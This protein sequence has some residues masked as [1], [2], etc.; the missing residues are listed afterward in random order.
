MGT[1]ETA[2]AQL[3][4]RLGH[5]HLLKPLV[6]ERFFCDLCHRPAFHRLRDGQHHVFLPAAA[7][8]LGTSVR[9]RLV[10]PLAVS[11]DLIRLSP[12]VLGVD[13]S[14]GRIGVL[15]HVHVPQAGTLG[16]RAFRDLAHVRADNHPFQV[17]AAL[18]GTLFHT[19]QVFQAN[20][21]NGVTGHGRPLADDP[22]LRWDVFPPQFG[23][24]AIGDQ[25]QDLALIVAPFLFH[26]S[27]PVQP[28]G[29]EALRARELIVDLL[30]L[31][32]LV[33]CLHVLLSEDF[34]QRFPLV[35][36]GQVSQRL[37]QTV[38]GQLLGLL[39]AVTDLNGALGVGP[40]GEADARGV[41][42]HGDV[43]VQQRLCQGLIVKPDGD[44]MT[45]QRSCLRHVD[46]S[47]FVGL[48][49]MISNGFIVPQPERVENH[50]PREIP[51]PAVLASQTQMK[52]FLVFFLPIPVH[53]AGFPSF[54]LA[55][56][57]HSRCFFHIPLSLLPTCALF[58]RAL[59][60]YTDYIMSFREG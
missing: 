23:Q 33:A 36:R 46:S 8:E 2:I 28:G 24:V 37:R 47:C 26:H 18:E 11:A 12:K 6:S 31:T 9:Q 54:L 4:H 40:A 39:P 48:R 27:V 58:F 34:R 10:L 19:L 52:I 44:K 49:R 45:R 53:F 55:N 22:G 59:F 29:H 50:P 17:V 60:C 16:E 15:A 25:G 41:R 56:C 3:L 35:R 1:V 30:Q 20:L 7:Q 14:Q 42:F 32:A 5:Y 57:F 21:S 38:P 43:G 51:S 13:R